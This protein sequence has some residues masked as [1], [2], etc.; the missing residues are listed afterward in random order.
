LLQRQ[1]WFTQEKAVRC[2]TA[3]LLARPNKAAAFSNGVVSS[4]PKGAG[5]AA[6]PAE[7]VRLRSGSQGCH[8]VNVHC[9]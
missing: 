8:W 4:D 1:D 2:L 3:A 5:A 9:G 7:Q 6:D